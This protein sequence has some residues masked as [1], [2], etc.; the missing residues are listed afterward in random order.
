MAK[1]SLC[2]CAAGLKSGS[3]VWHAERYRR[4]PEMTKYFAEVNCTDSKLQVCTESLCLTFMEQT[5]MYQTWHR[6]TYFCH[7]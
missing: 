2:S 3:N 1:S 6:G 7:V 4:G 5:E